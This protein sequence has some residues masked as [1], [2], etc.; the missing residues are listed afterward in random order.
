M[1]RLLNEYALK[2]VV[3]RREAI[4]TPVLADLEPVRQMQARRHGRAESPAH[5]SVIVTRQVTAWT[6][7]RQKP[8]D[9]MTPQYAV[10]WDEH[11]LPVTH[12]ITPSLDEARAT[13]RRLRQSNPPKE[14]LRLEYRQAGAWRLLDETPHRG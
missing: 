12:I 10:K 7:G 4:V 3:G 1:R 11:G 13:Y 9:G 2:A 6:R 5:E 14:L 8:R